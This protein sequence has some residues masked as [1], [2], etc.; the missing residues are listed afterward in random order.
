MGLDEADFARAFLVALSDD[1]VVKK[2]SE[3]VTRPM[4]FDLD[5][6]FDSNTKVFA[7]LQKFSELNICLRK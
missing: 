2:L 1:S 3:V 5:N 4:K 6:L 7:E